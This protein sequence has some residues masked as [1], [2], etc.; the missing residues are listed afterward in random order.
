MEH[1]LANIGNYGFPMVVAI[2]LL[3]RVEKKLESLTAAINGLKVV[4]GQN[5]VLREKDNPIR[6]FREEGEF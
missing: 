2:Y 6:Q 5:I 1:I 3:M 4:L